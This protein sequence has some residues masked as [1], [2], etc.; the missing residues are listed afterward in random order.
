M[1]FSSRT[2]P[3]FVV[4]GQRAG[5][6][7]ADPQAVLEPEI[8]DPRN[9]T[10]TVVAPMAFPR[11]Y[12]SIAGP[13]PDARV[14]TAGGVDPRPG[15]VERDQRSMEVFSPPYLSMGPR[16]VITAAS[17]AIAF[18]TTYNINTPTRTASTQWC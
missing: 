4:G 12:H 7:N 15:V 8:Y 10:W 13:L 9:D 3:I 6:W 18:G 14:L 11:Q 17:A 5:K 16:P 2:A 1:R